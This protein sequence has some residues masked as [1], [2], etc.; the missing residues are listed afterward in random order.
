[1]ILPVYYLEDP[2]ILKRCIDSIESQTYTNFT[3]LIGFDGEASDDLLNIAK[4]IKGIK[5]KIITQ[6]IN[7]GIASILNR[8]ILFAFE[9]GFEL[10]IRMDSDDQ[11]HPTRVELLVK[12]LEENPAIDIVG[13]YFILATL[14]LKSLESYL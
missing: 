9:S 10:A 12:A 2:K 6:S 13:S 8:L 5:S 14:I 3:L 1:M 11:S 4:G 7:N